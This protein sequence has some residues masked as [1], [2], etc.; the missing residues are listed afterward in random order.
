VHRA[1][2]HDNAR[3]ERAEHTPTERP[4]T[5]A[6]PIACTLAPDALVGRVEWITTLN[7][8]F[9]RAHASQGT[10]LLLTYAADAAAEVRELVR[11]ERECCAFL[12][13]AL[14]EADDAVRLRIEAPDVDGVEALLAPFLALA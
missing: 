6:V 9:L 11:R 8:A 4:M 7:R 1:G 12:T 10:A 14:D 2:V 3:A 5:A 13:F